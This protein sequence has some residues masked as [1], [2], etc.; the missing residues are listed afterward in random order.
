MKLY[1]N[2]GLL[3]YRKPQQYTANVIIASLNIILLPYY[4]YVTLALSRIM[5]I[6]LFRI[7]NYVAYCAKSFFAYPLNCQKTFSIIIKCQMYMVFVIFDVKIMLVDTI[8]I[9]QNIFRETRSLGGYYGDTGGYVDPESRKS[10]AK[11]NLPMRKA[12]SLSLSRDM[13]FSWDI[14]SFIE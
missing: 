1:P 13:S 8:T 12:N 9:W 14:R 4:Y 11:L 3:L 2:K 6:T 10:Q 5:L 7:P